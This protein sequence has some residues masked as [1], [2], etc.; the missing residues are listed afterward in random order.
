[1][2]YWPIPNILKMDIFK[3]KRMNYKINWRKRK[4]CIGKSSKSDR[5]ENGIDTKTHLWKSTSGLRNKRE[6]MSWIRFQRNIVD[7]IKKKA[8]S[9]CKNKNSKIL[10]RHILTQKCQQL[11]KKTIFKRQL[12]KNR[13]LNKKSIQNTL[14]RKGN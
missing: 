3:E 4:S 8:S 2:R 13:S 1:M 10:S 5:N 7:T 6:N 9:K 11:V 12:R 14:Q